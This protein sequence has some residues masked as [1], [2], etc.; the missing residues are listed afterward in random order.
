MIEPEAKRH[1]VDLE[2]LRRQIH[3]VH[4]KLPSEARHFISPAPRRRDV[5]WLISEDHLKKAMRIVA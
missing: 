4:A 1:L 3:K 5:I 2:D